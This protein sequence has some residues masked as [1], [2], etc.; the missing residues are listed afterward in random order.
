MNRDNLLRLAISFQNSSAS[1]LDKYICKIAETLF[2][3][4]GNLP[5][6][7]FELSTSIS[8]EFNL[9][10]SDEE[11]ILAL[12]RRNKGSILLENDRYR[13]EKSIFSRE[14]TF[15]L[16]SELTKYC[17]IYLESNFKSF[18]TE[19]ELYEEVLNY[20]YFSFNCNLE[21]FRNIIMGDL[22]KNIDDYECSTD[23]AAILNDFLNWDNSEKNKL[24]FDIVSFSFEYCMLTMKKDPSINK[25]VFGGKSFSLDTNL[26]IRLAGFNNQ[27]RQHAINTFVQKC[28][29]VGIQLYYTSKTYDELFRVIESNII[30]IQKFTKSQFPTDPMIL[31]SEPY[32]CELGD[33]YLIY[34][35]WA[36]NNHNNFNDFTEFY[37]Y[38]TMTITS[39]LNDIDY[40]DTN[41]FILSENQM[42]YYENLKRIK[43]YYSKRGVSEEAILTDLHNYFYVKS[44]RIYSQYTNINDTKD[45]FISADRKLINWEKEIFSGM[46]VVV[47][48]SVWTSI[49]LKFNGRS[50]NDEDYKSFCLFLNIR[51]NENTSQERNIDCDKILSTLSEKTSDANLKNKILIEIKND[52]M[53]FESNLDYSKNVDLAFDNVLKRQKN[54][55]V[56]ELENTKQELKKEIDSIREKADTELLERKR[57]EIQSYRKI[58]QKVVNKE[59]ELNKRKLNIITKVSFILAGFLILLVLLYCFSKTFKIFILAIIGIT[60][61]GEFGITV[62]L[63]III[64]TVGFLINSIMNNLKEKTT[65]EYRNS[66]ID[67]FIHENVLS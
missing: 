56:D 7:A 29:I 9:I 31:Q 38:L 27:E 61:L 33:F 47:M 3:I 17:N 43:E 51:T 26:I 21:S 23:R 57:E 48:P 15:D 41:D 49:I 19:V 64:P 12:K 44:R 53:K 13:L 52:N 8:K 35:Q 60:N 2:L 25:K 39:V 36:R 28:K 37:H 50:V 46:P 10:F 42:S 55:S 18:C 40:V 20:L 32:N 62:C 6:S 34:Y 66:K 63:A 67:E 16:S 22:T 14:K 45:F 30:Y 58:A 4:N 1:T 54:I 11:I 24:I 5:L 59:I 65:E